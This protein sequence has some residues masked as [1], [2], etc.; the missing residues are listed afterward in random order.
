MYSNS[1]FCQYDLKGLYGR[2]WRATTVVGDS[3]TSSS[4][5]EFHDLILVLI[6][7]FFFF[8]KIYSGFKSNNNKNENIDQLSKKNKDLN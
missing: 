5:I 8:D 2:Q 1:S 7:L 6:A 3:T 4:E